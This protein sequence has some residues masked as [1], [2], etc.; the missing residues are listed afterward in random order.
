[1][2]WMTRLTGLATE[3][4]AQVQKHLHMQ[5]DKLMCAPNGQ[6]YGAGHLTMP[7]LSKVQQAPIRATGPLRVREVVADVQALHTDPANAGAVFQVASQ[8]NM[9]E[10]V[11]PRVSPEQGVGI[12]EHDHTQGPACAIACGAGTI[13]RNYFVDVDGCGVLGQTES[14]QLNGLSGIDAALDNTRHGYWDMVNGYMIPKPGG[15]DRLNAVLTAMDDQ[16]QHALL[17]ALAVG[18]HAN[19]EV[20]LGGAGHSVTQIYCSALPVSYCADPDVAWSIF[21]R[22]VLKGAYEATLRLAVQNAALTGN[23]LVFLT[24]LGGGAFGNRADWIVDAVLQGLACVA[25]SGLDVRIVSY[26]GSSAVAQDILTQ[27]HA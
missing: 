5:A 19:V 26:G 16:K 15:L 8:F 21:A 2:T 9:L 25:D 22:L 4:H 14:R 13:F 20:T 11:S 18:H 23:N 12:Y 7:R 24:L 6:H 27:W 10:M 1:M 17:G 3:S